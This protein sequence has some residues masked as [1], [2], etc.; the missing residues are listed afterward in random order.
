MTWPTLFVSRARDLRQMADR[1]GL[2]VVIRTESVPLTPETAMASEP[3]VDIVVPHATASVSG[4]ALAI[5]GAWVARRVLRRRRERRVGPDGFRRQAEVRGPARPRRWP[6]NWHEAVMVDTFTSAPP[7]RSRSGGPRSR[8][9]V[10]RRGSVV[11]ADRD[12]H[13][14]AQDLPPIRT[15]SCLAACRRRDGS[16]CLTVRR[17]QCCTNRPERAGI[18]LGPGDVRVRDRQGQG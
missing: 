11:G 16:T 9:E 1:A 18:V 15:S 7:A 10:G 14:R 5:G 3:Y 2:K 13:G 17:F 6:T 12:E 4:A 8:C